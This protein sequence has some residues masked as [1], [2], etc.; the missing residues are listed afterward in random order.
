MVTGSP[1]KHTDPSV[2]SPPNALQ[3]SLFDCQR[4]VNLVTLEL[5]GNPAWPSSEGAKGEFSIDTFS[6]AFHTLEQKSFACWLD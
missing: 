6:H 3:K 1:L 4:S 5:T 2:D